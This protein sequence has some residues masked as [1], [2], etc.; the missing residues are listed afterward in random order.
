MTHLIKFFPIKFVVLVGLSLMV[1]VP[2][3]QAADAYQWE[4]G[5]GHVFFGDSPPQNAKNVKK[6]NIK[7][8]SKYSADKM[9]APYKKYVRPL[10]IAGDLPEDGRD[11]SIN[12]LGVESGETGLAG[13]GLAGT[14]LTG[15]GI[16]ETGPIAEPAGKVN[17][18]VGSARSG[19]QGRDNNL[20]E[21]NIDLPEDTV[22]AKDGFVSAGTTGPQS[23][24]S[25]RAA[26][27]SSTANYGAGDQNGVEI[28]NENSTGAVVRTDS[29][30]QGPAGEQSIEDQFPVLLEQG[31]L[32]VKHNK[33]LEVVECRVVVFNRGTEQAHGVAVSFQFADGTVIPGSGSAT[34]DAGG[35]AEYRIPKGNLPVAVR[36]SGKDAA[37]DIGPIP[38][39]LIQSAA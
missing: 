38:T 21:A 26:L 2:P 23:R 17:S 37:G 16:G 36:S 15:P 13:T 30:H 1:L 5:A 8:F 22:V 9:L 29:Q 31:E 33:K 10:K 28:D 34:I 20:T 6:L 18:I 25:D 7:R 27:E 4:D 3:A 24:L 35:Q 39:V 14:G 32:A 19:A 12:D 11:L